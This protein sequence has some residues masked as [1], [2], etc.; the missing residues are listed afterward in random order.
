MIAGGGWGSTGDSREKAGTIPRALARDGLYRSVPEDSREA[1]N[2]SPSQVLKQTSC[3]FFGHRPR[4]NKVR[5]GF[6]SAWTICGRC[7]RLMVRGHFGWQSATAADKREFE[8]ALARR[9]AE[10]RS[11]DLDRVQGVEAPNKKHVS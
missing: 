2:T 10:A 6:F 7:N 5:K 8:L 3:Y 4:R 11:R 9:S 1:G